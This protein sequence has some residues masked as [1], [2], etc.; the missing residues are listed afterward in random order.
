MATARF[1]EEEFACPVCLEVLRDPATLPCGHTY[2]LPCIQRHWDQGEAKKAYSCP[3]C[4]KTF[5]PRPMLARS[6]LLV[7]AMEKLKVMGGA[8][9]APLSISSAPLSV[10]SPCPGAPP[11]GDGLYPQL[12]VSPRLCPEH[13]QPLELFCQEDRLFVCRACG[14]HA[15]RDHRVVTAEAARVERQRDLAQMQ[16]DTQRRIQERER[17]LQLLPQSA[18][19]RKG[20]V[21]ALQREAR[22]VFAELVRSVEL[23]GVQVQELLGAHEMAEGSRV[24]GQIHRLE[25]DLAR[26]HSRDEELRRLVHMQDHFCFLKNFLTLDTPIPE[27]EGEVAG[28]NAEAVV[29]GVQTALREFWDQHQELS[30][31]SLAKIFRTVNDASALAETPRTAAPLPSEHREDSNSQPPVNEMAASSM[32]SLN[33]ASGTSNQN[34]ASGVSNQNSASETASQNPPIQYQEPKTRD[35]LLKFRF[36][37]TLDPNTA[38]RQLRLSDGDRKATLRAEPQPYPEHAGRF[39]FWRQVLCREPLAG[40]PCYWEAEWTG[41]KVTIGVA[42]ASMGR[43]SSDESCRLGHNAQS[44]GLYWTGTGFSLWHGG[45]ETPVKG[46]KAR[47]VGVYL[48]Q[49]AGVLAFYRVSHGQAELLV[50][51]QADFSG[52]LYPGFRFWTGVGSSVTLCQLD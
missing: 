35:E 4:R 52:P 10:P 36:E 51:V 47:R 31:A 11:D 45:R 15:H 32:A 41:T 40:S 39:L 26:L 3:Q 30:K 42:Y 38:Y 9:G 8:E 6:T 21:Q 24:E 23:A 27:G 44:W 46:P 49:Q 2:C 37:P 34:P 29:L 1:P 7:E 48:D 19:D 17:N 18:R 20:A 12:P 14:D 22:E 16:V 13:R 25:Q 5:T 28:A 50:R 33:A 43:A